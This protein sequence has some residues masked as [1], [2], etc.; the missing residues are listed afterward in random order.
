[1]GDAA[2]IPFAMARKTVVWSSALTQM[3]FFTNTFIQS[4]FL[5]IYFQ[6]VKGTSPVMAG[7]YMLPSIGMQIVAAISSGVMGKH[8][9][10]EQRMTR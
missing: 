8:T 5:P 3:F 9:T 4:F 1:M 2:M 10:T 7:V 6:A